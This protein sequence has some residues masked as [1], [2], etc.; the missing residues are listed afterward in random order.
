MPGTG[1]KLHESV[2]AQGRKLQYFNRLVAFSFGVTEVEVLEFSK[3]CGHLG[4]PGHL[5]TPVARQSPPQQGLQDPE[6]FH[7]SALVLDRLPNQVS[8]VFLAW[9]RGPC[10]RRSSR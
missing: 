7:D 2:L 6:G 5:R 3:P 9:A 8:Y 10:S 1:T 4:V